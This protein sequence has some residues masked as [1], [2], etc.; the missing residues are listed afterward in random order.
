MAQ[1]KDGA[2]LAPRIEAAPRT[3]GREAPAEQGYLHCGSN[4]AGHF[5]KMVHNGIEYGLMAAYAEGLNVLQNAD[6]GKRF[7]RPSAETTPARHYVRID[8][9]LRI[10]AARKNIWGD[11]LM[12][13]FPRPRHYAVD[14]TNAATDPAAAVALESISDLIGCDLDALRGVSRPR[15]GRAETAP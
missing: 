6:I 13:V 9:K 1:E 4:A 12:T 7:C 2:A 8:D 5:V 3:D 11:R 14:P 15:S 10:L